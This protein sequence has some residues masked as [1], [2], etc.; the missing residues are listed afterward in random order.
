MAAEMAG[1]TSGAASTPVV[2][3]HGS[4]DSAAAWA[5]VIERL[6][7]WRGRAVAL[8]LPGHGGR[9]GEP[10]PEPDT[11]AG[12]AEAVR[13]DLARRGIGRAVVVGHSLGGAIALHLA[14]EAPELVERIALVGAGARMRVLP[15]LLESAGRDPGAAWREAVA[16]GHAP[17][18]E[19]MAARYAAESAPVAPNAL[20]DDLVACDGFDIM[21]RLGEIGQPALVVVGEVDRLTPPKYA[22]FL[23]EGL[24][25]ARLVT[26]PGAGHFAM[27]EEPE[28]VAE[29]LRGWLAG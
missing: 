23:A 5:G 15:A 7:A 13:R 8:D 25:H 11:V 18:H 3:I 20:H 2:L 29:A 14:L 9:L 28:G 16:L 6:G 19:E 22:A 12:Y 4:G 10:L 21:A 17:G 1:E 26:L 24:P 27:H